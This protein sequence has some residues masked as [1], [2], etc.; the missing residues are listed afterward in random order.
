MKKVIKLT[1]S[2]LMRIVKRVLSEQDNTGK[3][4][5]N[6]SKET[7]RTVGNS[8]EYDYNYLENT[9]PISKIAKV[10]N[11][12]ITGNIV[13]S[14]G[15]FVSNSSSTLRSTVQ[16]NE[17]V[18]EALFIRISKERDPIAAFNQVRQDYYKQF[19]SDMMT[20]IKDDI[21]INQKYH[22]ESIASLLSKIQKSKPNGQEDKKDEEVSIVT[23]NDK[24]YDYKFVKRIKNR[25]YCKYYYRSK[26]S[27]GP[28]IEA[29][30]T[31]LSAI[32]K[33]VKFSI[34]KCNPGDAGPPK[35]NIK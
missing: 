17:A 27:D 26:Q 32:I 16:D 13:K 31:A 3:T 33:T 23:N 30:G 35:Y 28:W 34:P 21:D 18:V 14:V 19:K 20:D 6:K 9:I 2:D 5:V 25:M 7:I 29:T 15:K 22:K 4:F 10:I 8:G 24:A 11:D 1:E 12:S